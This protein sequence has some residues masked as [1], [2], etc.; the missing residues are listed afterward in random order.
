VAHCLHC[1]PSVSTPVIHL[2]LGEAKRH[3][4]DSSGLHFGR[5]VL[6]LRVGTGRSLT[7]RVE[8][9]RYLAVSEGAQPSIIVELV[10][11]VLVKVLQLLQVELITHDGADTT[12]ALDEL[13]AL[14]RAVR[15]KLEGGTKVAVFLG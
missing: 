4:S 14:G 6:T 7:R 8:W 11:I 2:Q 1:K 9:S 15:D 12:E 3:G 10:L 5:V 13:I